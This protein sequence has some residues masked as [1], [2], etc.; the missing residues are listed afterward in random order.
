[1]NA[2]LA[3]VF[4]AWN[5]FQKVSGV[6][7]IEDERG[8][9]GATALTGALVDDG[10]MEEGHP[11]HSLFMVL[12]DL[13]YAYDQHHYPQSAISG[14]DL[15]RFLMEQHGLKQNQLPEIGT[16]SVVSEILSGRRELT[17]NHIRGLSKRF[18]ISPSAF[19]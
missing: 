10:A 18:A 14:V 16:Q 12:S 17:V 19:F 6:R 15:L 13:I 3:P 11:Q 8:Y 5:A 2:Q 9:E 1:M 4:D 7:H